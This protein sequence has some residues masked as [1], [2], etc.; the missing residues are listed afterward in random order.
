M[1]FTL[2]DALYDGS[3]DP[4]AGATV[5]SWPVPDDGLILNGA[6]AL[7]PFPSAGTAS[8]GSFSITL[9]DV[10]ATIPSTIEWGIRIGDTVYVGVPVAGTY[11]IAQL[12]ALPAPNTWQV[13]DGSGLPVTAAAALGLGLAF[14]QVVVREI[15]G[16][17]GPAGPAGG[18]AGADA[19][20]SV[21]GAVLIDAA[22]ASGHPVALTRAGTALPSGMLGT[23]AST[24]AAGNDSRLSDA[25]TPLAHETTHLSGGFDALPWST[26]LGSGLDA[27][28]PAA[29]AT[30]AG[31]VWIATDTN[32]LYQSTGSAWTLELTGAGSGSVATSTAVGLV[33]IDVNPT[34]GNPVALTQAG[35]SLPSGMFA[36]ANPLADGTAALGTSSRAARGDH[37]HPLTVIDVMLQLYGYYGWTA[38]PDAVNGVATLAAGDIYLCKVYVANPCTCNTVLLDITTAGATPTANANYLGIYDAGG[39]RLWTSAS[40]AMDTPFTAG[41]TIQASTGGVALASGIHYVA[42]L[43]NCATAPILACEGGKAALVN[44]GLAAANYRYGYLSGSNTTLPATITLSNLASTGGNVPWFALA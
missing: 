4:I 24:A 37:V 35:T 23:S 11:T 27:N 2:R 3:G 18:S 32:K 19:T 9:P 8:N 29:A 12:L 1:T 31:Y 33:Q 39:N 43:Q 38:L 44:A 41:G 7:P 10:L 13:T 30:N 22:P 34:S 5:L 21:T 6:P 16:P 26:I 42:Y 15:P 40:G 20:T 28:K 36:V 14:G 17:E 25:R